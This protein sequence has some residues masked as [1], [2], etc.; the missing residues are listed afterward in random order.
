M[1]MLGGRGGAL[2][3]SGPVWGESQK[4]ILRQEGGLFLAS[5][6]L[7]SPGKAVGKALPSRGVGLGGVASWEVSVANLG[8]RGH[9]A[10]LWVCSALC[11]AEEGRQW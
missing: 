2:Y 5:L 11:L 8:P 9:H 3:D 6:Q 10:L 4:D 7:G 1:C